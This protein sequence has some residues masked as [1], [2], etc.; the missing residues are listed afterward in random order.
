MD[1]INNLYILVSNSLDCALIRNLYL[2]S[3]IQHQIR[4][5][6]MGPKGLAYIKPFQ[7]WRHKTPTPVRVSRVLAMEDDELRS[8]AGDRRNDGG[9][10]CGSICMKGP[11]QSQELTGQVHHLPCCIRHDGPCAVSDYFKPKKTGKIGLFDCCQLLFVSLGVCV[12]FVGCRSCCGWTGGGGGFISG[13]E[14]TRHYTSDSRW[15]LW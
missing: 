10:C 15:L 13:A 8:A 3:N 4:K 12:L 6:Y 9:G 11:D 14:V 5:R 7:K 2:L 1:L